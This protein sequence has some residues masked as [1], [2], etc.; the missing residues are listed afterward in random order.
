MQVTP[1]EVPDVLLIK[2][3][4]FSDDR[5]F[6]FESFNIDSL[7]KH[8]SGPLEFVQDNQS[9]SGKSVLRGL[10]YQFPK[11]QGKLVRAIIGEIF[12]VAVDVRIGSPTCG[13]WVSQI[14][15][16][17][18]R[19][20]LWI[21]EGFAHGFYVLS[22][23]AEVAYKVTDYYYPENERGINWNDPRVSVDWPILGE[24]ILSPKDSAY[25]PFEPDF[26]D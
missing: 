5:G 1:L 26:G 25:P 8:I 6:F 3:T 21:P 4:V 18:N 16:A 19:K 7:Q 11:P 10:H 12:D 14:I 20:Q 24:P 2:P 15:T 23:W 17:K 22:D 13:Q 9:G